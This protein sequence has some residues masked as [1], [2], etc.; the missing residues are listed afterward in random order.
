MQAMGL[1]ECHGDND[2]ESQ[3][4]FGK[5]GKGGGKGE[6]TNENTK[7]QAADH[8]HQEEHEEEQEEEH[9]EPET[10]GEHDGDREGE[11]TPYPTQPP[12]EQLSPGAVD[13]RLRRIMTP[14]ASGELKVP[15]DMVDQWKN[16]GS[17]HKVQSLFEKAGYNPDW[18]S[19]CCCGVWWILGISYS[20]NLFLLHANPKKE[21]PNDQYKKQDVWN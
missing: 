7:E 17:R 10:T 13:R 16:K 1:G 4:E 20:I 8:E 18:G 19:R 12:K 2:G 6:Q 3:V 21:S 9:E 15:Q 11:E 5:H 14:R